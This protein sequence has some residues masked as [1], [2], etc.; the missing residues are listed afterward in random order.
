MHQ[1]R[2]IRV[3]RLH[4]FKLLGLELFVNDA[5]TVPQQHVGTGLALDVG[6]QVLVRPPDDGFAVIHQAFDDF[7]RTARRHH[8]VRAGFDRRRGIGVNHHRALR[9]LVAERGK[10][11]DRAPEVQRARRFQGRH[12]DAFFGVEDLGRLAHELHPGDH[13]GLGRVGV[14]E[15]GHLKRVGDTATGFFGQGLNNRIAIEVRHQHRVL[16][17]EL[18]SDGGTIIS[19]LIGG[20]RLGLLGVEVGL[21]QK[22]FGNLRHVR[23]TC[24]RLSA[25][26]EYTPQLWTL[27]GTAGRVSNHQSFEEAQG[28]RISAGCKR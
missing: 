5:G 23:K 27:E 10:L 22:A 17:L 9:M 11:I 13:H 8:P 24:R 6:A 21:N 2:R 14:A 3:Q 25:K 18:G 1:N 7:Q 4:V 28:Y 26:V 16:S 15:A 12:Q 20:Q 19:F